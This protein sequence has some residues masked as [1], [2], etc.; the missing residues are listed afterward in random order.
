MLQPL[1]LDTLLAALALALI[2]VFVVYKVYQFRSLTSH[3]RQISAIVTS[4]KHETGKTAWGISRDA[5]YLSA[6]WTNPRT[7]RTY[8]FWTWIM[9]CAPSYTIGSLVPVLID[10]ENPN[11]F[12]VD[13]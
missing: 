3:G 6:K 1:L 13:L 8:T 10:P 12:V 11:R 2:S 4:I 9:N 5:Y 7:G